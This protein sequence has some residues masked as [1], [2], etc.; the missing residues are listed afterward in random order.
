VSRSALLAGLLLCAAAL[1]G[2]GQLPK[3][4]K[5]RLVG[6]H[7][8]SLQWLSFSN[9]FGHVEVTEEAD[10]SI[11][12][13]GAQEGKGGEYV[14]LEG[15]VIAMPDAR[16][17]TLDGYVESL[18]HDNNDGKPCRKAGKLRFFASGERKYWRLQDMTNC[19]FGTTD[20]VDV[21]FLGA[22]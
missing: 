8:L 5:A 19:D 4:A 17:F 18:V 10:G 9:P 15:T 3:Q 14:R 2:D 16:H 21:Y 12:L 11:H 22:P 13:V 7:N 6:K 20:Y 1:A